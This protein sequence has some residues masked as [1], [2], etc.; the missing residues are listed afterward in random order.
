MSRAT[1]D[2]MDALHGMTAE[3]YL[4]EIRKY[5]NGEVMDSD[6]NKIPVPAALLTSAAKFLKDNGVDRPVRPGDAIDTLADE[7]PEFADNVVPMRRPA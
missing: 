4:A 1:D 3:A 7:L 2:L 6:G 5:R